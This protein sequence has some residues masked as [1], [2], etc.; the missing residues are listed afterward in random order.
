MV[1]Y[2]HAIVSSV[3][4]NVWW[5][6]WYQVNFVRLTAVRKG[7]GLSDRSGNTGYPLLGD[8]GAANLQN[9][10][11]LSSSTT[12][13][14]MWPVAIV[15]KWVASSVQPHFFVLKKWK[16]SQASITSLTV[17]L[18]LYLSQFSILRSNELILTVRCTR[19]DTASFNSFCVRTI[20]TVDVRWP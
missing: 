1:F 14:L 5:W 20:Q 9:A 2:W 10:G 7:E 4:C 11:E 8:T 15:V 6:G 17:Q 13:N 3:S 19:S 18:L 12:E 16:F